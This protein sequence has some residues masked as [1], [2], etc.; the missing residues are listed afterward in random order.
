MSDIIERLSASRDR[1]LPY[2]ELAE[3]DLDRSYAPGKWSVRYILHHLAD[4]ETVLYERIRRV[5]G[6]PRQV[7]WGFDQDGWAGNLG[8]D[9]LPLS[10][11]R[12]LFVA[13]REGVIFQARRR[14]ESDGGR[15]FVHS[16][17]GVR[18]LK[19]EIDKVAEHNEHHLAHI[20]RALGR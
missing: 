12:S 18:T 20:E 17:A 6:E 13:A 11:S 19:Q 10:I 4:T 1:T 14:Y 8:Y 5:I 7:I 3:Q 9:E 16:D 2:F 15:E